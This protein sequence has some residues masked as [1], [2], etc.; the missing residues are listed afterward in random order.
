MLLGLLL[1]KGPIHRLLELRLFIWLGEISY[2]V[3]LSHSFLLNWFVMMF[4][5]DSQNAYIFDILAY[6]AIVLMFSTLCYRLVEVSGRRLISRK[7]T[8]KGS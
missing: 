5:E 7:F 4:M 2:S 1:S 8:N 6:I 3:Y